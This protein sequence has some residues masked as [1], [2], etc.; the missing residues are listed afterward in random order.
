MPSLL[1][2]LLPL[3]LFLLYCRRPRRKDKVFGF[4]HPYCNDGGG[5]ERVLWAAIRALHEVGEGGRGREREG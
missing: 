4:F 1:L 5:G 3:V 2:I